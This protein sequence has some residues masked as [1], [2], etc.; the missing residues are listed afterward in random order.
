VQ[1]SRQEVTEINNQ[2]VLLAKQGAFAP[3][4]QLLRSALDKL[5]GSEVL[6]INLCGLLIAQMNRDGYRH[7][8]AAEVRQ[9]L[10]QVR[11]INPGNPKYH[12]Y[13]LMVTRLQRG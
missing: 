13:T 2:G 1:A 5:P 9:S 3:G 12:S 11:Q 4:A 6:L 8:L 7:D 10:E